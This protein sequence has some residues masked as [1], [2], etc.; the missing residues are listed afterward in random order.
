MIEKKTSQSR[1]DM[2]LVGAFALLVLGA[3][4]LAGINLYADRQGAPSSADPEMR[5]ALASTQ[6]EFAGAKIASASR[7][8]A[9]AMYYEARSEGPPGQKAVA[10]VVLRRTHNKNYADTVCGVVY[11]GVQPGKKAGCQFSFACDGSLDK[12]R[13]EDAWKDA[14]LLAEKIMTGVI[15]LGN[16][17]G[18]AIAY[19][20]TD[21]TPYWSD[22]MLKT[23]KIGNHIFYRFM[24]R[25]QMAQASAKLAAGL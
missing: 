12:P 13:D 1:A 2:A 10:E 9:E 24:P 21:V 3:A 6:V 5:G 20:N 18:S 8:L 7:C 25:D 22:T 15:Q 19:H 16:Q 17:T 23:A 11:E 4:P 14:R